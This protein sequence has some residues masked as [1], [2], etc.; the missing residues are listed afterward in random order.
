[1]FSSEGNQSKTGDRLHRNGTGTGLT[2]FDNDERRREY[3]KNTDTA[4]YRKAVATQWWVEN[5]L[6]IMMNSSNDVHYATDS[7]VQKSKRKYL[8]LK[9]IKK[10]DL[11]DLCS[12][13]IQVYT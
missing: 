3:L 11:I 6:H 2:G 8:R 7:R 13:I 1:M 5:I 4:K 10:I 9:I 12:Y